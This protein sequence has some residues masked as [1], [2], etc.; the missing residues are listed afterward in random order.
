MHGEWDIITSLCPGGELDIVNSLRPGVGR[1]RGGWRDK[2]NLLCLYLTF[3]V[4]NST[5]FGRC[6]FRAPKKSRF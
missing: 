3:V 1:G 6:H 2:V 4:R 5:H